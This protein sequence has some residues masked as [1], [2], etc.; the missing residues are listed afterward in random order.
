MAR[1]TNTQG[2]IKKA[3]EIH[4]NKYDYSLSVYV[5]SSE[6]VKIICP[7][8]GMFE[9][10]P[11]KH[12]AGQGCKQ[13]GRNRTKL[14][15]Q[16]F[17]NRAKQVHGDKYDYS[18][19]V[20]VN[21]NE[22]VDIICP[23]HG[24]FHQ[25]PH[26]HIVNKQGCPKCGAL[27]GGSKRTGA[28]NIAH[29]QDV[30]DKKKATCQKKY[31]TST[32]A[33]SEEGRQRL[34]DIV[35]SDEVASKMKATCQAKYGTNVWSQS[36]EGKE[37]LHEIMSSDEIKEKV[38]SGYMRKYGVEHYMKTDEGREKA[39]NNI[40]SEERRQ[41]IRKS[42]YEKYGA[43]SFMESNEYIKHLPEMRIK[44]RKTIRERYGV[45]YALQSSEILAKAWKTKRKNGTFN[46]S[47]PEQTMGLL[48]QDIF[49]VDDVLSQYKCDRYP[50]ACDF[51]VKS[52]DLF[53]ELNAHWSHGGHWFDENNPDD[54][55]KLN[56]WK[57]KSSEKGSRYYY[58][59]IDIWTNRDLSKLQTAIDNNLNYL[60][61]WKND[62]T[63][64]YDWL[65]SQSLL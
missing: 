54:I 1:I 64:F 49:G 5:K 20:Y 19:A 26:S 65:N 48:L 21:S 24:I 30:K 3:N 22:K 50:F 15:Q 28:N 2:F 4:N 33:E 34:H 10:T 7:E 55:L 47:K 46:T 43:Y 35:I 16:E 58:G 8:H 51:Y 60:V 11:N 31:G 52:L 29:R 40:N 12:L 63:D 27:L 39:R 42:M 59:A 56:K 23:V 62:L 9:M 53:V 41:K 13:C 44:I 45:D 32:W 25:T 57:R 6:K 37:K 14:T 38:I 36:D 61:F 18:N 17:I